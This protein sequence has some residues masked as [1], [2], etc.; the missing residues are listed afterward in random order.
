MAETDSREVI[1]AR[2]EARPGE[3]EAL[4]AL[5]REMAEDIWRSEPRTLGYAVYRDRAAPAVFWVHEVFADRAAL[6]QHLDRH[7]WRRP[8]FDAVLV[9]P[10]EFNFCA[11]YCTRKEQA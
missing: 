10:A 8:R 9:R 7:E 4:G 1:L 11:P 6:Q 3:G 2:L 5:L